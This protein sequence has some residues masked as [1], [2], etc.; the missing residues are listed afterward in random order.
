MLTLVEKILFVLATLASLYF[1]YKGVMKIVG[2]ICQR[3]GQSE[4]VFDLETDWRTHRQSGIVPA[5]F[6]FQA[7]DRVFCTRL[8]GWGF[9]SFLLINLADLIY[10]Y[11]N[12]KLLENTGLFGDAYRL[13]ADVAN[14]A[15]IVGILAMVIRRFIL[16]PANLSTRETT[17]LHP[18]ARFGILRDS[19]IV[20]RF[21]FM[22]NSM[23]V[24]GRIILP[25]AGRGHA[26]SWQ[27]II[28]AVAGLWSGVDARRF[29]R[30]RTHRVLVVHWRGRRLPALL[31]VFKTYPLV[32]CS[33]EFCVEARTKIHRR[34]ELHQSRRPVHRTVWRG[35]DE[36]PR[37]GADHGQLRLH[38]VHA[39]SGSLPRVQ[40][41]ANCYRLPR[42]RSTNAIT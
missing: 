6:S 16:R 24:F 3:T 15:I 10:A 13:L 19:A 12:F 41:W 9:L 38:H 5:R 18:K 28:S 11:T 7:V 27:P 33:A 29:D 23:R 37:L 39:L 40:H 14:V 30:G 42:W 26:D 22:H 8:I 34:V 35:E 2:H 17:L 21:I 32:L 25:G 36:R 1:T 20:A 31:P 4:L